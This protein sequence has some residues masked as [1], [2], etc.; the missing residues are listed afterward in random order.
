MRDSA[1]TALVDTVERLAARDDPALTS[2]GDPRHLGEILEWLE[3]RTTTSVWNMQRSTQLSLT[4]SVWEIDRRTRARGIEERSVVPRRAALA[5]PLWT[6]VEPSLR[7]APV[8]VPVIVSD[9]SY[10]MVQGPIGVHQMPTPY[11]TEDP[12]VVALAC[13]AFLEVW[14][15]ALPWPEAGL[16]PPLPDRRFRVAALLMDGNTDREIAAELGVGE[17][18]VSAEVRAIIDWLGARNRTHA[19]AMLV[20]A[21]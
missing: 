18:T 6:T 11:G 13:A 3:A 2:L 8:V 17:R 19:V 4:R 20:G 16:L 21:A 12:D 9:R 15:A 5:S 1:V 14:D 10:A 7:V